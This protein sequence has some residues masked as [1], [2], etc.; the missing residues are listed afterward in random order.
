MTKIPIH[1]DNL[2][3]TYV[4]KVQ[5]VSITDNSFNRSQLLR[6]TYVGIWRLSNAILQI[7]ID[8]FPILSH[9]DRNINNYFTAFNIPIN[10]SI[11]KCKYDIILF[12]GFILNYFNIFLSDYL[13]YLS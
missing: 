3:N 12:H 1:V 9:F 11:K 8:K 4:I 6:W 10:Q 7:R 5:S 2:I 13:I